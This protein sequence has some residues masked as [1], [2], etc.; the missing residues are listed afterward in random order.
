MKTLAAA[1]LAIAR[2]ANRR[3]DTEND[4]FSDDERS[5]MATAESDLRAEAA[6]ERRFDRQLSKIGFPPQMAVSVRA[7]I[8]AN[9]RRITLTLRQARS[10]SI[11]ELLSFA[12]RTRPP[13]RPSRPR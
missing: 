6:T 9:A 10:S 12:H 2:P 7:L 4:G 1:Y 5:D 3:L 8:Q 11:T 13:T